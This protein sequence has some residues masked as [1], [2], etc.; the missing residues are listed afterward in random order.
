M[1]MKYKIKII[2]LLA[3]MFIFTCTIAEAQRMRRSGGA[4]SAY[5]HKNHHGT[6]S[7]MAGL[8]V[9]SY[10]GD[11]KDNRTDL[12]A[13]PSTQLGVQYRVNNRLHFRS[14]VLWYRISGA[15]SLNDLST[16]IYDRNLSFQAD[17]F[18][19][20]VVSVFHLF[21]KYSNAHKTFINPYVFGGVGIT[22]NNAKAEYNGELYKL[23]LLETE[24]VSY[25]SYAPVVPLGVGV[26]FHLSDN[27]DALLE[28]GYRITFTDYLDDV[29]TTFKGI[30]N[31]DDPIASALS[32]RRPEKGLEP[33]APGA[34][35]GNSSVDDWYLIVGLKVVYSPSSIPK[36]FRRTMQ[37]KLP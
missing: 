24:G 30:N 4:K 29:S 14:E 22:T 6:F 17:N 15:D 10:Y 34:K 9:C 12:W 27:W 37:C 11:L 33:F 35:R 13:K 25:K 32:D 2:A 5:Q 8:G 31:F 3:C 1:T 16:G 7:F 19:W 26:A 28:W 21:N 18:E 23:R 36:R 20:N